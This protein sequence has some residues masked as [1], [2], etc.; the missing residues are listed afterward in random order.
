MGNASH[1]EVQIIQALSS[2][3]VP[4]KFLL[5]S[6]IK[7]LIH[8]MLAD[9]K[10]VSS[11]SQRLKRLRQEE[12]DGNFFSNWWDDRDEKVQDAQINLSRSIGN[13]TQ[14]SSQL[15]IINTAISKVL[16][17][18]QRTLLKQQEQLKQQ[19]NEIG[20]QNQ[21]ILEQQTLLEQQQREINAANQG[22]LEAKG[23]TQEQ[24]QKLVGCVVRVT[25]AE[26]KIEAS[27][28][29]LREEIAHKLHAQADEMRL[30]LTG[31]E[32]ENTKQRQEL[33]GKFEIFQ[34]EADALREIFKT[35]ED[36]L[37]AGQ[38]ELHEAL[39][40]NQADQIKGVLRLRLGIM[41]TTGLALYA[42]GWQIAAHFSLF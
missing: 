7:E 6:N 15:I 18:Q 16:I 10:A 37:L 28:A 1:Q 20:V 22:L 17:D 27:N 19:A 42:L 8:D 4:E 33:Q 26:K 34:K 3:E 13:L 38:Q 24:A 30:E 36:K 32:A 35:T 21:K 9:Q 5:Q 11:E 39:M 23:I 2:T 12:K 25:E 29:Q 40:S 14:R 31:Q 41:V